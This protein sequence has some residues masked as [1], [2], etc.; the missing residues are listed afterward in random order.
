MNG[1]FIV[2]L[3]KYTI[4]MVC[5]RR[6]VCFSMDEMW[7]WRLSNIR[8]FVVPRSWK[9]WLECHWILN[10]RPTMNQG[11]LN[12]LFLGDQTMQIYIYGNFEGVIGFLD[13]RM[14]MFIVRFDLLQIFG[15]RPWK[16]T[17]DNGKFQ[18]FE[19]VYLY[20]SVFDIKKW[21]FDCHLVFF[22]GWV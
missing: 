6:R 21:I 14:I 7:R 20:I 12:Y 9:G 2:N 5:D 19:D 8:L 16:L 17:N 18:P 4:W 3:G 10:Y 1:W 15:L 13:W 22:G 11:S